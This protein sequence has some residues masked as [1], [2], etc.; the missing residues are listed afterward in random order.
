MTNPAVREM[1]EH[2][3]AEAEEES[4]RKSRITGERFFFL[5]YPDHTK[6]RLKREDTENENDIGT[7]GEGTAETE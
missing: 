7:G 5:E 3:A 1:L 2:F 6:F 4:L